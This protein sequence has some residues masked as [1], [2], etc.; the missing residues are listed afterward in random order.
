[1]QGVMTKLKLL[2]GALG[3]LII[4][5]TIALF[6]AVAVAPNWTA[7]VAGG[8]ADGLAA[9]GAGLFL[10]GLPLLIY[11]LPT[12]V[13]G[14]RKHREV[15]PIFLVNLFLGWTLVGWVAALVWASTSN[16]RE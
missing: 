2:K 8:S 10:F 9:I 13:A 6:I 14:G 11:F 7:P 3:D 15:A 4:V 5:G 16:V 1:M 12:F